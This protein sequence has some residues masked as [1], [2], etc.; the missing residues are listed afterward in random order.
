MNFE[1]MKDL[2]GLGKLYGICQNAELL[3]QTDPAE[4]IAAANT[5]ASV[6]A[7]VIYRITHDGRPA[8]LTIEEILA[9]TAVSGHPG[10]GSIVQCFYWIQDAVQSD[11]ACESVEQA[12]TVLDTLHCIVNCAAYVCGLMNELIAF[13]AQLEP[14]APLQKVSTENIETLA[15]AVYHGIREAAAGK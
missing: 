15:D 1:F 9:D 13:D 2:P 8:E 7:K 6:L 5:C 14:T 10:F 3:A 12:L 4:C 11:A